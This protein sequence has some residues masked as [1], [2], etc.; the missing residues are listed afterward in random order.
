MVLD[1]VAKVIFARSAADFDALLSSQTTSQNDIVDYFATPKHAV[2]S[3][4]SMNSK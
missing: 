4:G 1:A 3:N 2:Q